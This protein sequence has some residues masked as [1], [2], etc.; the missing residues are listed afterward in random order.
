M[1]HLTRLH[2]LLCMIL[3]AHLADIEKRCSFVGEAGETQRPAQGALAQKPCQF[4]HG[5]DAA[6]IV[7]GARA[8]G[9]AIVMGAQ[10][11]NL[12]GVGSAFLFGND[13]GGQLAGHLI[14]LAPH[15]VSERFKRLIQ[16]GL[17]AGQTA[18][19][20]LVAGADIP[21]QIT[22]MAP[23]IFA[24]FRFRFTEIG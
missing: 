23:D 12:A 14:S 15:L 16:I 20:G 2:R 8:L 17:G 11:D 24:D 13:I 6:G 9:Y 3:T 19:I 1:D 10:D 4:Q 22:R 18:R 7:I 21:G 5:G